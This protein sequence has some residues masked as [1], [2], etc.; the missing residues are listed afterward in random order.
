MGI[1]DKD[2]FVLVYWVKLRTDA[3]NFRCCS[4]RE[5]FVQSLNCHLTTC[6]RRLHLLFMEILPIGGQY[7]DL[8]ILVM[9]L[10]IQ[11]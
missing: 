6:R 9:Y 8:Q 11:L 7:Q 2:K 5:L 4:C 10:D 1:L 3:N